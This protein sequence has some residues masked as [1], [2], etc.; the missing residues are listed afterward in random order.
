MTERIW[1]K[2][3]TERDRQVFAA[4]GY[5]APQGF[6]QRPALVIVDVNYFF[7]GDRPEPILESIK[8]WRNSCGEDAWPAIKVIKRLIDGARDK[9]VPVVYTTGN[10]RPDLWNRGSWRSAFPRKISP[11]TDGEAA[12]PALWKSHISVKVLPKCRMWNA[13]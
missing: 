6:G 1:D 2:F 5:G 11:C 10:A 4:A 7:C 8:R 3:L 12:V 9:G 13:I